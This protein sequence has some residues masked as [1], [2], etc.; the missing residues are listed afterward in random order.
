MKPVLP[1]PKALRRSRLAAATLSLERLEHRAVLSVSTT[2]L[3]DP[4]P[5]TAPK[6]FDRSVVVE[7]GVVTRTPSVLLGQF[8]VETDPLSVVAH[9]TA[10]HGTV[11]P[12]PDG[13]FTYAS[14]TGYAGPDSFSFTIGDGRGGLAT[15]TMR[16][17]VI[18][19][20]AEA[21]ASGFVAT[22]PLAVNGAPLDL[23]GRTT[24][25][26][27]AVDFD[28]DGLVDVLAGTGG[29][30]VLFK[31]LGSPTAPRFAAAVD[32]EAGGAPI[33][34]G[35]GRVALS[36]VDV[37]ADGRRDLVVAGAGDL[38]ARWYRNVGTATVP[39][40]AAPTILQA[41]D[42][43][44]DYVLADIRAD[45][46]DWNGDGLP[47][48]VTGSFAGP[49][50]IA[51]NLGTA[52]EPAFA[53][54]T[55]VIDSA[56][57]TLD[58]AYN[59][60]VRIV[61]VNHDGVPDL[62]T[63]YNWG[64]IN[65]FVNVG[66][67]ARPV[68]ADA[69]TFS[70]RDPA[71]TAVDFWGLADGPIV[72]LADLDGDGTVDIVAGGESTTTIRVGYGRG[73]AAILA[74]ID[75]LLAAHPSDLGPYLANPAHAADKARLRILVGDLHDFI[76]RLATPSQ[77]TALQAGLL[78][79][80]RAYPQYFRMQS[81]DVGAQPG[82]PGLA[83]Q[84][85]LTTLMT[86]YFDPA[87][88]TAV[89]DAAGFP[90]RSSPGGGY[91]KLVEDLGLFLFDNYQNPRGAEAIHQFV[92]N[93]PRNVYPGT[94]I[95]MADWL[96]GGDFLVRGH[97]KNGFNG[98]PD[99]GVTEYGFGDD[100]RTVIGDRGAE[101][102]Y[103]TVIHHETMHDMDAFVSRSPDL[104]RRWGQV[105]V[106]AGGHDAAG[107][108]YLAADPVT[109]WFSVPLTQQLWRG[110][111]LWD[112]TADWDATFRAFYET[113]PGKP[114]NDHGFMRGG[115]H[116]FLGAPQE[117]LATQGNQFWNSGEGRI[118][119]ALDRWRRGFDSD[120]NEVLFFMDVLSLGLDKMQ[121]CE[122]DGYSNQVI[123]F[124]SLHRDARGRIDGVTVNGREYRF[125]V[126]PD[127]RVT[128]VLAQPAATLGIFATAID[129]GRPSPAGSTSFANG[130][131]VVQGG[132]TGIAGGFDR[133]HLASAAVVGDA[134]IVVRVASLQNGS[135]LAKAGVMF[136]DSAAAGS[137]F[138]GL[139]VGPGG[140]LTFQRR[141]LANGAILTTTVQAGKGPLWLRLVRTGGK[142]QAFYSKSASAPAT[143]TRIG[144]ANVALA[145]TVNAGLAVTSGQWGRLATATLT[146]VSLTGHRPALWA[147]S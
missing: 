46:A 147:R 18:R 99:D 141:G 26:P 125:G 106:H 43:S 126:N 107:A 63:S 133:F 92:R 78:A 5:N 129:V 89:C 146:S 16:V 68:L 40:F 142:F 104:L 144:A 139:F 25:V 23:G 57:R 123:S 3:P 55:T 108:N 48:I 91:R 109:G 47:D 44:G 132:G 140:G 21:A 30:V 10:A 56:G 2:F 87:T 69:A 51:L 33:R 94:G 11:A 136:R 4:F 116:W 7:A 42:G 50:R 62:V 98:Y 15:G 65:Y 52:A 118:Q 103:M 145:G 97:F 53:A 75:A 111:G 17:T 121:L 128:A 29:R 81:L 138:V 12:N 77:R 37:D 59:L 39:A 82:I 95:T 20:A 110:R 137:R 49:V 102:W 19:A 14:V 70:V 32:V 134:E 67:A 117:S 71:G 45:V 41:A 120:I 76:V 130:V 58:G 74:E 90:A 80:I 112:G 31:N 64:T 143:W 61:D 113:G 66:T 22:V 135:A 83:A 35:T 119:V 60:N 6:V 122:N 131:Y 101:N 1:R 28:G 24:A 86:N 79:Q 73:G 88:R 27:R 9:G 114:W 36:F 34:V 72:D 85:L 8:D 115:I 100:A 84:T 13:T 93:L 96:G 105:L 54:P 124:A 127:G 38:L